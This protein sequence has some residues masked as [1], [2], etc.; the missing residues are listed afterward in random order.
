MKNKKRV[1]LLISIC[2]LFIF[3]YLLVDSYK[4]NS[5]KITKEDNKKFHVTYLLVDYDKT[6][7]TEKFSNYSSN[8][9]RTLF[10]GQTWD[11]VKKNGKYYVAKLNNINPIVFENISDYVFALNDVYGNVID[12]LKFDKDKKVVYIPKKYFEDKKYSEYEGCPVK[13]GVI[14]RL[15]KDEYK[16]LKADKIVSKLINRKNKILLDSYEQETKISIFKY[17]VGRNVTKKDLIVYLNDD[18]KALS[19]EYYNFDATAGTITIDMD[20]I[21]ISKIDVKIK[22][23]AL[24]KTSFLN[25]FYPKKVSA[26]G[27]S[28]IVGKFSVSGDIGKGKVQLKD[29]KGHKFKTQTVPYMYGSAIMKYPST[30]WGSSAI[31][32]GGKVG[33]KFE[34]KEGANSFSNISKKTNLKKAIKAAF[35]SMAYG[36]AE[37]DSATAYP[38]FVIK[39]SKFED[40]KITRKKEVD[41]TTYT[42]T[43]ELLDFTKNWVRMYCSDPSAGE[44]LGQNNPSNGYTVQFSIYKI[45][46]QYLTL[47]IERADTAGSQ[48][49]SGYIRFSKANIAKIKVQK[50][51]YS[52]DA[53]GKLVENKLKKKGIIFKL[54]PSMKSDGSGCSGNMLDT[55]KTNANGVATFTGLDPNEKYCVTETY[56]E[57]SDTS[58]ISSKQ[59]I[60]ANNITKTTFTSVTPKPG[61]TSTNAGTA[62]ECTSARKDKD[63]I[64]EY[65]NIGVKYCVV[66]DKKD[67]NNTTTQFKNVQLCTN[68]GGSQKCFS[69]SG[70]Q[71]LLTGFNFED[72]YTSYKKTSPDKKISITEQ[73]ITTNTS[74][75]EYFATLRNSDGT[76]LKEI[77]SSK[78]I[79]MKLSKEGDTYTW[80]CPTSSTKQPAYNLK[81]YQCLKV[82]KVD[83]DNPNR[84]L[85]GARFKMTCNNGATEEKTTGS[86]GIATFYAGGKKVNQ[87]TI[88]SVEEIQSPEGYGL[89]SP[90]VHNNLGV[91]ILSETEAVKYHG[92]SD[93]QIQSAVS[94]WCPANTPVDNFVYKDTAL[95]INWYKVVEDE[96]T[97]LKTNDTTKTAQ[98]KVTKGGTPIYHKAA[99]IST[100]NSDTGVSDTRNCYEYSATS[101]G[102]GS[103]IFEVDADGQ[104]C[105]RGVPKGT[106]RI[107]ETRPGQYHTFD[108]NKS[109][110]DVESTADFKPMDDT[111]KFINIPTGLEFTKKV[112]QVDGGDGED[113]IVI[114]GVEK[115]LTELTTEELKKLDFEIYEADASNNP[116]GNPL[117][118]VLENGVYNY[119]DDTVMDK[120]QGT[121]TTI[122]HLNDERKIRVDHLAWGKTY[123]IREVQSKVC[124]SSK[125][126]EDCIG[127]YYPNY[128]EQTS[129]FTITTC[130]NPSANT[131]SC[132]TRGYITQQLTN[133]PTEIEFTKKDYYHYDDQADVIDKDKPEDGTGS[134]VEFENAKERSDFDRIVFKLKDS[135]NRYL[136]LKF[137]KNHGNCL[138]E[139]SYSE[140]RYVYSSEQEQS[141]GSELH[142]CGGHMKITNL[143]RGNNYTVEEIS[144]PE[145]SV[146]VKENTDNTPTE[147]QYKIP[148][149]DGS[150]VTQESTTKKIEDKPTRVRFEK[151]DSKYNYLI[152]DETTTFEVYRCPKDSSECHPGD[153]NTEEE[154]KKAG[155]KLVKFYPR[156]V[157][158]NDEEDQKD[159][160]DLAG[161][162][163]YRAMSDSDV[164]SGTKY[165]TSLHPYHG[166]LVL[167]YLQ[168]GYTYSLLETVAPKNYTLPEGRNAET[169]FTVINTTVDV[170][171]KDVPNK[172]TSLLIKKY[173]DNGNLLSGAQFRI[174]EKNKCNPNLTAKAQLKEGAT[175]MKLKTIRDGV[176]ESRPVAD[177]DTITTCADTEFGKC[178][179]I[180]VNESTKLT[181]TDYLD[182]WAD[183]DDESTKTEDGEKIELQEG[184]A[185][186]QYL[187]YDRCY[188]VEEI[189]APKG[190]SLPKDEEDRYTMV[191]IEKNSKYAHSTYKTLVNTPT[192]FKFYK[193]DEFNQLLDGAEFKLQK[194][195]DNKKYHD[196]TVTKEDK[197]DEVY[198][199]V[200]ENTDNVTITTKNG[201][202]TV[203]YLEAGQYRILET[204]PA[205]G[206]EL[207]K[208]PNIATFFV[209]DSGNVYGNAIIVNKGKTERIEVK[210]TASAELVVNI[211]TGQ[212]VLRYGLI[213]SILV[214]TIAGLILLRRKMDK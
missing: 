135:N 62:V 36:S 13:M 176:Y 145:D 85:S 5:E 121:P 142:T 205:P 136:T 31:I 18:N 55:Q 32:C 107:T 129:S 190:Y 39:M 63:S 144:V 214:A 105:V 100:Q 188:I 180:S 88:C 206:K 37:S 108:P 50:Y 200:D 91:S 204:K 49:A 139:D 65:Y 113:K 71:I 17:G 196:I 166:I 128:S 87:N 165:E 110:I 101:T 150:E 38:D 203:Y 170:E 132:P 210:N 83:K 130:S 137:V 8:D 191:T 164:D 12:D 54:Y 52:V 20:P 46:N 43:L 40:S 119:V 154:R 4:F 35:K 103:D 183:F 96:T 7:N 95:K 116:K 61:D 86:D 97:K 189:K 23:I 98:F 140:Y 90:A 28:N 207:S 70:N 125:S 106:Y 159:A 141:G 169:S 126:E 29:F 9:K 162:E 15:T 143:C 77:P 213:I 22:K 115:T 74:D 171:E 173:S 109:Y 118:F 66:V 3:I 122:L 174:Y 60:R 75:Q 157:M 163:V 117:Q 68:V 45:S 181:Y 69:N 19:N 114:N 112:K 172:P 84:V 76:V 212:L 211:Q 209:D 123:V 152:P 185:L 6:N 47:R 89:P 42:A 34:C 120:K 186:I 175:L 25:I 67:L 51:E 131:A 161:V 198:Y 156:A 197:D 167:R 78:A 57:Y 184:E 149:T 1:T 134:L 194:L 168:S 27:T 14:S 21:Y 195:D 24:L 147:V 187:E 127:Y 48:M 138:T 179:D 53:N 182:T 64:C 177:T 58:T 44:S 160:E 192:P 79:A 178:S 193:Y 41:D 93:A 146:F 94:S 153:Y 199:K 92:Q 104:V 151:R 80:S 111:N 33:E 26:A 56:Y 133:T 202:A 155:M 99:K 208:N 11:N 16:N 81:K 158:T 72:I 201:S 30:G 73:N 59:Y 124:D 2:F 82:K 102:A 148:C 10:I